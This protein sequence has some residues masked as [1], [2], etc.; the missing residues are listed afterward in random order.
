MGTQSLRP[1]ITETSRLSRNTNSST[2]RGSSLS[3]GS[4]LLR[5]THSSKA[6]RSGRVAVGTDVRYANCVR[7]NQTM[8]LQFY[9]ADN[10]S[11]YQ[12][13]DKNDA[14]AHKPSA[15]WLAKLFS[16]RPS[17]SKSGKALCNSTRPFHNSC[18]W[19]T[20]PVNEYNVVSRNH[21]R[22]II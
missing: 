11:L 12:D 18:L 15:P 1:V 20:W 7:L 22:T 9:H 4:R 21:A 8:W 10:K 19:Y 2:T 5:D 13:T 14:D 6:A 17:K 16:G 3:T